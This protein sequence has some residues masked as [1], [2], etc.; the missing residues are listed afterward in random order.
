M[1][2]PYSSEGDAGRLLKRGI[3]RNKEQTLGFTTLGVP[4]ITTKR[5]KIFLKIIF[6]QI[7]LSK[8]FPESC[9]KRLQ[10]YKKRK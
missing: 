1:A 3:N 9:L 6:I 2:A 5:E 8:P 10:K 7:Q 4:E